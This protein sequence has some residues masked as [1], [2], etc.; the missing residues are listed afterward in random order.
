ML[1]PYEKAREYYRPNKVRVLFV[2]ESRPA[3]GTFFYHENSNLFRYTKEAF[4]QASGVPFNCA[5][6]KRH[7]CWLYDVC[8]EPVN[9]LAH[10]ERREKIK[11][12]LPELEKIL[13]QLKPEFVIAVKK[14][15]FIELASPIIL[16]AGFIV[17]STFFS[18]PFPAYGNQ[19]RF[20]RELVFTLRMTIF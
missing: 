4:E 17:G 13:K 20:V 3:E 8:G 2:G 1:L 12:G 10:V 14:G 11:N 9:N 18:L 19:H 5:A 16:D 6:F 7:G 15:D